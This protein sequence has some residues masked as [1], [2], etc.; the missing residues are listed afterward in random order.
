[1]FLDENE[2]AA[3]SYLLGFM[4]MQINTNEELSD[5]NMLL[6]SNKRLMSTFFH[7]YIHFLQNFTSTSGLYSSIFSS[8]YIEH[9]VAQVKN[10]TVTP[11][12]L[13]LSPE[14]SFNLKAK[15][16]LNS[17][18]KGEAKSI[19]KLKYNEYFGRNITIIP[20]IGRSLNIIKYEVNVTCHDTRRELNY[21]FGATALKEYVA[22]TL[23]NY[24][25]AV[26]HPDAPY[27]LA[28]LILEKELPNLIDQ[29]LKVVLCD[30]SLMVYHP[31]DFFF[32]SIERLKQAQD[33]Y[34]KEPKEFYN[35]LFK[36]LSFSGPQGTF[37]DWKSL[38]QDSQETLKKEYE[39]IFGSEIFQNELSWIKQIIDEAFKLRIANPTFLLNLIDDSGSLTN[40]FKH[41]V[42][43]MGTPYFINSNAYAGFIPPSSLKGNMP[44]QPY[45]LYAASTILKRLY[46]TQS[47]CD[48][49]DF[50]S[51]SFKSDDPTSADC[52][53]N[54]FLKVKEKQLCPFSQISKTWGLSSYN[55]QR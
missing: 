4:C 24:L 45:L 26:Q 19:D 38:L 41:V 7:E 5:L 1:M 42:S 49:Y 15:Y 46:T 50:C 53:Q 18:Y 21:H 14:D 2:N 3:G 44:E 39:N 40:D 54:P 48:M 34:P 25:L 30:A 6:T 10:E 28:E 8:Q 13:P 11:I 20:S 52:F 22:H 37:S 36:D 17:I 35:F 29:K 33:N 32:K 9:A 27:L 47:R 16:D 12:K 23:Q 51:K 55:L 43:K 31:A